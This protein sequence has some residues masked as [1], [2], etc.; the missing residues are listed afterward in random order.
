MRSLSALL[1]C[2]VM[3]GPTMADDTLPVRNLADWTIVVADDATASEKYAAEQFRS[4][5][6]QATG[7][8]LPVRGEPP[9]EAQN[10]WIG[11]AAAPAD[12]G[13]HLGVD[14]LGDEGVRIRITPDNIA[15][16][17]GRPRGTLYA[18]FQFFERYLGVRFLT[19]DHTYIPPSA[20]SAQLP[21]ET[22]TYVC[23]FTFRWSYYRENQVHPEFAA[24][25]RCNTVTHAEKLGGVTPQGLISHTFY[26]WCPVS[27]YGGDHPEYFALWHGKRDL[28]VGGGGSELCVTN[29]DVIEIVAKAICAE[30]DKNPKLRNISCSQNDNN[31][32]CHCP[33]CEKI[34]QA[35]GTPMGSNLAFVNA[36]AER[37]EKEHPKV[38]VGTLAYWY[39]RHCPKTIKPRHNVQIQLCSIECCTLHAI[40]DPDCPKNRAFCQDME[41]WNRVCKQIWVWN[42][43]TN[44][45]MYDLPFPN[46]HSIGP[47]VRFFRRSHVKGIFMQANNNSL[48]GEMSDLRNYVISR[49][50]WNPDLDSWQLAKEFCQLHYKKAAP[51]ILRHLTMIHAAAERAGHHPN[52]F[53]RPAVVGLT[54]EI[55]RESLDDFQ[56]ALTLADNDV[57]RARVEKASICAYRAMLEVCGKWTQ[58]DGKRKL[59]LPAEYRDLVPKYIALC[60]RYQMTMAA[61][62]IPAA[63]YF[64]QIQQPANA[65]ADGG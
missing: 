59:V 53:Q 5:F 60:K 55:C 3:V 43:N 35:E 24:K 34:N 39:T 20:R 23:P 29:P 44:F 11:P 51:P 63:T 61:E 19:F 28:T 6:E 17:G 65:S 46:L 56:E 14:D 1:I 62:T 25:L 8:A 40:D 4:L 16:A 2:T 21:C 33:R 31:A 32:Y 13:V 27:K 58:V 52:C 12:S 37:V 57:V 22:H 26:R 36:V 7:I 38:M 54:K 49:C 42:Y 18:V 15:I 41:D 9:R 45:S 47:N 48:S 10:V 64:E 50:L 30:L